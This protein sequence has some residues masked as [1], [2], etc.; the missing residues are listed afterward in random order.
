MEQTL[1]LVALRTVVMLVGLGVVLVTAG[2][3]G[4]KSVGEQE[5]YL[6][7][8]VNNTIAAVNVHKT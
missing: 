4:I 7:F 1:T 2:E 3:L 8:T 6:T 5:K